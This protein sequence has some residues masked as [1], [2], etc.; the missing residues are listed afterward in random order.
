MNS[1]L[2]TVLFAG[3]LLAA[4]CNGPDA[5]SDNGT[6]ADAAPTVSASVV[7]SHPHDT[8]SFT[9]GLVVYNGA[10]LEGTGMHGKSRLLQVELKTGRPVREVK[11]DSAF[12]GE[13]ITVLNDTLYQLT[14]QE[15][16][17]L[18]YTAKD[19]KKIREYPIQTEGWGIT[20]NGKDLI[21]SDGTSNL[22]FYE[23]STFRMLRSQSVT[24]NGNLVSN[25][26]ELEFINGFLYANQWMYNHL[27]KINAETG[28]VVAR[29]DLTPLVNQVTA[30]NPGLDT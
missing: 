2:N 17:V 13:G 18:V 30:R 16:K 11:L 19:F 4:G 23:P 25:I 24:E 26:N 10:L 3:A 14:W 5:A 7:A 1:L 28:E 22:Y 8:A 12:F 21:V 15:K 29:V 27:L 6:A 20:H 9:Q